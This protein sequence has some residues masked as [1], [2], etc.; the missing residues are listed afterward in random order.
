MFPAE[1]VPGEEI[2]DRHQIDEAFLQ[3]DLGDL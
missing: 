3:W 1:N 2:Y